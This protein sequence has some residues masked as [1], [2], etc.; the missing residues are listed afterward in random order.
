MNPQHIAFIM[1]G[2]RRWAKAHKLEALMGHNRGADRIETIV[3]AAARKGIPYVTFWA[4]STENWKREEKEVAMLFTVFRNVLAGP[5]IKR[6][7]T[8][9]VKLQI[10]GDYQAFPK[11]IVAGLESLMEDSKDNT[12]ITANIALNY[13]GRGEILRAIKSLGA[14]AETLLEI[15]EERFGNLL[16]TAGLP[17]PDLVIRTGG[18]QRL[19]GF[20][21]W[22][23]VY[24]ELYFTQTFWPDF[25]EGA[26]AKA[27]EEFG[28]RQRRFGK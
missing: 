2:N 23:T 3:D 22:Q 19:S 7:I 15:D 26:F 13:G 28:K 1:D 6:L 16:Y 11:D 4:F 27:L 9:G 8:N 10:I 21:A 14:D 18:E 25:D 20:L 12:K 5:M 24:S 17:D